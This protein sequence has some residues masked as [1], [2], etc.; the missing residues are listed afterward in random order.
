M[1]LPQKTPIHLNGDSRNATLQKMWVI[2][3]ESS[4]TMYGEKKEQKKQIIT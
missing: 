3:F 2:A 1:G 4:V